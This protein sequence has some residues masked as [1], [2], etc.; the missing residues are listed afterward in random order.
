M[1][2]NKSIL[3]L[4]VIDQNIHSTEVAHMAAMGPLERG[5]PALVGLIPF[6][7]V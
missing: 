6:A 2:S 3:F 7:I 5:S 1:L 4:T